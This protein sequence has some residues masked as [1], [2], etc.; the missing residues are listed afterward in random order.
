[1][2]EVKQ[3][4]T[5][6]NV[7][8]N[9]NEN[10]DKIDYLKLILKQSDDLLRIISSYIS[11][12]IYLKKPIIFSPKIL[13]KFIQLNSSYLKYQLR[14]NKYF[15][16][17]Y[18]DSKITL[19]E[20]C[21]EGKIGILN[22]LLCNLIDTNKLDSFNIH[23]DISKHRKYHPIFIAAQYG[24]LDIMKKLC[25]NYHTNINCTSDYGFSSLIIASKKGYYKIVEFILENPRCS[26][27]QTDNMGRT[28]LHH[29]CMNDH[30]KIVDLLLS[31]NASKEIM[32]ENG[33]NPYHYADKYCF[34]HILQLL[35]N[36]N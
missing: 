26:I 19:L 30:F 20:I 8:D 29:A 35:T 21:K 7:I 11:G 31:K 24:H 36:Y 25:S 4:G 15:D 33:K 3:I 17:N 5:E 34:V 28:A 2:S 12:I 27:D 9:I 6:I 13:Y 14:L 16:Y 22:K 32:D 23:Y 18:R 1:M 10:K